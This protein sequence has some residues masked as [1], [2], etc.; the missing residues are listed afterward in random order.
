[1]LSAGAPAAVAHYDNTC[2]Q[3]A[4]VRA[5]EDEHGIWVAGALI[6][7]VTPEQVAE[8]RRSP[9]SGD[10]RE[11]RGR[12]ELVAA[13]AVNSSGFPIPHPRVELAQQGRVRALVAAGVG[14]PLWRPRVINCR[15]FGRG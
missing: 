7:G 15:L 12:L 8:L 9:L 13:L 3:I 5:G 14:V 2:A 11:V 10:W 1:M 6:P 4:V